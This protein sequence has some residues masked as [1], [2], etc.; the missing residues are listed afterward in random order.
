[1]L[2]SRSLA[3][4]RASSGSHTQRVTECFFSARSL[5]RVVPQAPAPMTPTRSIAQG[6][7]LAGSLSKDKQPGEPEDRGRHEGKTDH[8]G[9]PKGSEHQAVDSQPLDEEPAHGVQAEVAERKGSRRLLQAAT[10]QEIEDDED[11]KIPHRFAKE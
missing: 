5:A 6:L 1:M 10:K 4:V 2:F 8:L 11:P 7:A 9:D 3:M